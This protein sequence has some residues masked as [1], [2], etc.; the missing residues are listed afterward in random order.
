MCFSVL[1]LGAV[2]LRSCVKD[3]HGSV[4]KRK[5]PILTVKKPCEPQKTSIKLN[6]VGVFSGPSVAWGE[7]LKGPRSV[8][9]Q[10][11]SGLHVRP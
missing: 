10:V 7:Q 5:H 8:Q 3:E 2:L 11:R 6:I 4:N 9:S 1:G